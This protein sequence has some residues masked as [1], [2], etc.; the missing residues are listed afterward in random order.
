MTSWKLFT[1]I[2]A[3]RYGY[4]N[5][6]F[7]RETRH[8]PVWW[9]S[10]QRITGWDA[11]RQTLVL[12]GVLLWAVAVLLVR[13]LLFFLIPPLLIMLAATA[14]TVGPLVVEERIKGSWASVLATPL[15]VEAVLLGKTGG[16]MHWIRYLTYGMAALLFLVAFGVGFVSL[17]LIPPGLA[18]IGDVTVLALCGLL[19][20][21]PIGIVGLFIIDRVQQY[22]L[23]LAL[24]LA[25]AV[26]VTSIRAAL[27]QAMTAVIL[28][29]AGEVAGGVLLLS[30]LP[31]SSFTG[32]VGSVIA[33]ATVGPFAVY[34]PH[35][36][37]GQVL[38]GALLTM[39][40]REAIVALVWRHVLRA[41]HDG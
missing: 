34:L 5:P 31:G 33:L 4:Q 39:A 14:F 36:A 37:L 25:A 11:L 38:A 13:D 41:A 10:A 8:E 12:G 20:I 28:A 2:V 18:R 32:N 3:A 29:W 30:V 22:M 1:H 27:S 16:A 9:A 24:V 6:V 15:G 26:H 17:V 40:L 35:L 19:V 21:I 7:L 23:V